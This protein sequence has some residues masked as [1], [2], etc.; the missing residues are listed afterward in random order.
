ME[1]YVP[2]LDTCEA[3]VDNRDGLSQYSTMRFANADHPCHRCFDGSN[4]RGDRSGRC[5]VLTPTSVE[6]EARL[7][8]SGLR[9]IST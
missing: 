4:K 2:L 7:G 9:Q 1:E 3:T 8:Q 5:V 6:K